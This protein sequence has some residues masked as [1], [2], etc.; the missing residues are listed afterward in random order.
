MVDEYFRTFLRIFNDKL[1]EI[2]ELEK[3]FK[4]KTK[5]NK[6]KKQAYLEI[7]NLAMDNIKK[8]TDND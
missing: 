2:N 6:Y 7:M 5:R 4:N 3:E 1:E 8:E